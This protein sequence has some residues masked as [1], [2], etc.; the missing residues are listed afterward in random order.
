MFVCIAPTNLIYMYLLHSVSYIFILHTFSADHD[1][2]R[3]RHQQQEKD[4]DEKK[5]EDAEDDEEKGEQQRIRMM[6]TMM[7]KNLEEMKRLS[8]ICVD[9]F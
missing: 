6:T 1:P 8:R 4:D 7:K 2:K 9:Y 3:K 5:G